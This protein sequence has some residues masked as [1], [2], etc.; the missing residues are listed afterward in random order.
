MRR[1]FPSLKQLDTGFKNNKRED[2]KMFKMMTTKRVALAAMLLTSVCLMQPAAA[3]EKIKVRAAYVP[4]VTWLPA[5]VAQTQGFFEQEGLEVSLMP[6]QNISLVPSTLGKQIDIGPATV[7]DLLKAAN[8]GLDVVA[9][10]GGH[11][12]VEGPSTNSIVVRKDSGIKSAKDLAGK[13]IATPT[14]GAILHIALLYWMKQEG[15]D[16]NSIRAIEVPFP[17]MGD[18]LKAG[19]VDAVEAVQPFLAKMI[20]DG[21][22]DLG[23]QLLKVASP[24]RSTLWIADRNWAAANGPI[25]SKWAAALNKA[26]AFIEKNPAEARLA[27]TKYTKLPEAVIKTIPLPHYSVALT[28]PE[29]EVWIKVLGELGQLRKP[30]D[31]SKLIVTAK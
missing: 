14:I 24:A 6:V 15:V 11:S 2:E 19:R 27:M 3:A 30:L 16:P 7:I 12:D 10:A 28:A 17:N 5:W 8:G 29:I 26:N 23:D 25:L 20:A 18:Q 31:A 4:A 9:V 21:N 22:I 13:T 1:D